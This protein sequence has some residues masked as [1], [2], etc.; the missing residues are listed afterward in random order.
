MNFSGRHTGVLIKQ[1][2]KRLIKHRAMLAML[3]VVSAIIGLGCR[4][5]MMQSAASWG[6]VFVVCGIVMLRR[7]WVDSACGYR[8]SVIAAGAGR[9]SMMVADFISWV[10]FSAFFGILADIVARF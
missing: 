4:L 2:I 3:V 5:G 7:V 8:N 1:S 9:L 6:G 10:V